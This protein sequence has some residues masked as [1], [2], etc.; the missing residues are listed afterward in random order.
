MFD[1]RLVL[2]W[3]LRSTINDILSKFH[4]LTKVWSLLIKDNSAILFIPKYFNNSESQIICYKY[5]KPFRSSIFIVNTIATD[6][7]IDFN[8]PDS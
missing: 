1:I 4:S 6:I 8:I 5:N 3:I 2:I 7:N